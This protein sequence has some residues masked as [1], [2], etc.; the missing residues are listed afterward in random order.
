M[1]RIHV[2][3]IEPNLIKV[4]FFY[5]SMLGS[6]IKSEK[7]TEICTPV[8]PLLKNYIRRLKPADT[9]TLKSGLA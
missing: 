8:S 7:P 4:A 2:F 1:N 6:K 9:K 3:P 5:R